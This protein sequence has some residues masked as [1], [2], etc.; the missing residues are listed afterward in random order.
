M[1][2]LSMSVAFV[3]VC[4]AG[5][6]AVAAV[7][8]SIGLRLEPLLDDYLIER[9]N[10]GAKLRLHEPTPREVV[11]TTDKPWE[12]NIRPNP[13]ASGFGYKCKRISGTGH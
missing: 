7:P 11:L 5:L 4:A 8:I 2:E 12:G 10:G 9:M 3:V 6:Q 13:G 1:Q